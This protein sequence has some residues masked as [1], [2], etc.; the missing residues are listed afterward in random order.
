MIHSC[1]FLPGTGT[2]PRTTDV[3][4]QRGRAR[5]HTVLRTYPTIPVTELMETVV[6][7]QKLVTRKVLPI[8]Q[9]VKLQLKDSI[10]TNA[11]L[12]WKFSFVKNRSVIQSMPLQTQLIILYFI[13]LF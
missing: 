13:F 2:A 1:H 10:V 5:G 3:I 7:I 8:N 12:K 11:Y 6:E 9:C 4:V